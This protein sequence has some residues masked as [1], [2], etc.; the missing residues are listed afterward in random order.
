MTLSIAATP[1]RP[2]CGAC[3]RT[4][5][6]ADGARAVSN[7]EFFELLGRRVIGALN[8]STPA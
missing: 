6:T 2:F 4:R 1:S 5:L 8:D 7:R 3:D